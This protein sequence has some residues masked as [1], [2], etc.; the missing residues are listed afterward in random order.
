MHYGKV[1]DVLPHEPT[2]RFSLACCQA[3]LGESAKALE[4]L[5]A[6]VRYG[7]DD[8]E[9]LKRAD[10]L[11]GVRHLPGFAAVVKDAEA[12]RDETAVVYAGKGVD[13]AQP[14]PLL[15]LLHG[16]G[17]GPRAEVPEWTQLANEQG[18]VI[19]APRAGTRVGQRLMR[20]W[21]RVGAKASA[22]LDM[23]AAT[24][25]VDDAIAAAK[26]RFTMDPE[27][28]VLAGFSQGGAVALGLLA[29][30]PEMFRGA[31]AV[32]T[33][34]A[35][36]G[37]GAWQAAVRKRPIRAFVIAGQLDALLPH[38]RR[39]FDELQTAGV[40]ARFVEIPKAGHEPPPGFLDVQRRALAFVLETGKS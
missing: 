22:E 34:Y 24:R 26:R 15:V 30:R 19:V 7:W 12:C 17:V 36:P 9:E 39:A 20:G 8:P 2:S 6:A 1:I 16:L 23:P 3:R 21:H 40:P 27:K 5:A 32:C 28:T 29:Q 37:V 13:P 35:S 33:V 25:A 31:V 18:L 38:S 4:S 10:D 14:S 11:A